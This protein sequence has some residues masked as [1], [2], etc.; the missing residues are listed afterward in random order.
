MG[1]YLAPPMARRD[2]FEQAV[3]KAEAMY[4][5]KSSKKPIF[6]RWKGASFEAFKDEQW[7]G[8]V[9]LL[10][11]QCLGA[12]LFAIFLSFMTAGD[13]P[14]GQMMKRAADDLIKHAN[15]QGVKPGKLQSWTRTKKFRDLCNK[16]LQWVVLVP[17]VALVGTILICTFYRCH[18]THVGTGMSFFYTIGMDAFLLALAALILFSLKSAETRI[19]G[20]FILLIAAIGC[21][22]GRYNYIQNSSF[23]CAAA[24]HRE[25]ANV[26]PDTRAAAYQDAGKVHFQRFTVVDTTR[27]LGLLSQG[28]TYCAAP[29][30]LDFIPTGML[31]QP[32]LENQGD[33]AASP[34]SAIAAA[35]A[36][37]LPAAP[38]GSPAAAPVRRPMPKRAEFWAVGYDCCDA[39]GN[40]HCD[41]AKE[42][43]ARSG[44]VVRDPGEHWLAMPP[45]AQLTKAVKAAAE[46]YGLPV[47]AAPML[48]RYGK[49]EEGLNK[50]EADWL[51]KA[52]G[53]II[54]VSLVSF[55]VLCVLGVL[56][57]IYWKMIRG[58]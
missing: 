29:I 54:V 3:K 41:D 46:H 52:W 57:C 48:V 50:I 24:M 34:G 18:R 43:G 1:K 51:E 16:V 15:E 21:Y 8:A 32:P 9:V 58:G 28:V 5:I 2:L 33:A 45:N 12:A 13:L 37:A 10:V 27:S 55:I 49:G 19:Y 42:P 47:P 35:P 44:V 26:P 56:V 36:A 25:Y 6:M 20:I 11:L 14:H 7:E 38:G 39:R 40:F 53:M 17:F 31:G 4:G 22:V 30:L 23:T